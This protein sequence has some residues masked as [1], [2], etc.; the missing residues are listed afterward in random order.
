MQSNYIN[1][2]NDISAQVRHTG[3]CPDVPKV[4][5]INLICWG[6]ASGY[7][8]TVATC[9]STSMVTHFAHSRA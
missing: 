6:V 8:S 4:D 7:Q 1:T 3:A 5:I 9:Y 2:C